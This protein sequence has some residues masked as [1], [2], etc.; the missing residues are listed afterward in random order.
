[1]TD[2]EEEKEAESYFSTLIKSKYMNL[3]WSE[4]QAST[5]GYFS[6]TP[7]FVRTDKIHLL[8]M[9]DDKMIMWCA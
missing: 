2:R 9:E 4:K 1:M 6:A 5:E 7:G 3:E 8:T